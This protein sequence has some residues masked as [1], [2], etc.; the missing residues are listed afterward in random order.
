MGS[1]FWLYVISGSLRYRVPCCWA[2][3][4]ARVMM[5]WVWSVGWKS[6]GVFS[7]SVIWLMMVV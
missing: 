3:L 2:M 5:G 7:V 6:G 1:C 4:Y